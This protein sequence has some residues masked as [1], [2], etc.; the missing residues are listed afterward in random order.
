MKRVSIFALALF[1]VVNLNG[2]PVFPTVEEISQ[3]MKT[4]TCVV[5]EEAMFSEYNAFIKK[6]V[7]ES[8][9]MTP[10]KFITNDEFDVMMT[11]P[12][13]SF[14]ILTQTSFDKDKSGSTYNYI[15]L[16]LGKKVKQIEN[17]PEFCAVPLSYAGDD[18]DSDE[19]GYKLGSVLLFMQQHVKRLSESPEDKGLGFLKYYNAFVPEI[20]DKTILVRKEDMAPSLRTIAAVKKLYPH[21]IQFVDSEEIKN[22]ITEKRAGVLILHKVGPVGDK[23]PGYVFKMLIGTDDSKIYFYGQHKIDPKNP[24]GLLESDLKRM[25]RF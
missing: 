7:A 16:L 17:M 12:S 5:L 20:A 3:I 23:S 10:T 22:A 8:W 4:T 2:Q 24:N 25:A 11:D 9:S 1:A 14:I 15:N 21:N 19:F 6:A 13:Y 18:E